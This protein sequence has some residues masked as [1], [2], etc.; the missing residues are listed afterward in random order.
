MPRL[1]VCLITK[2]ES[3]DLARCLASVRG[4]ADE[5][6]VVDTGSTDAT[7][8]IAQAHGARVLH[9]A[10]RHDFADAR[11]VSL[12]AATG[13]WVLVLDADDEVP[14]DTAAQI[15][16]LLAEAE[17]AR[18][19]IDGLTML[20]H[21]PMPAG[22]A[23]AF[24]EYP[25]LRLFRNRPEFRFR[26]AIHEQVLPAI[27]AAGGR[28]DGCALRLT[29]YGY[30]R[31]TVQGGQARSQRDREIIEGVLRREPENAYM[32]FQLGALA[33][34]EGHPGEAELYLERASRLADRLG[35]TERALTE[36][37]LS[38]LA[39]Q[40]GD[41]RAALSHAEASLAAE[42]GER[43][44]LGLLSWAQA[45]VA[46]GQRAADDAAA[47]ARPDL[48]PQAYSEALIRLDVS[49][50]HFAAARR[51]YAQLS[52]ATDLAT[53]ARDQMAHNRQLCEQ[54]LGPG[55]DAL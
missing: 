21:S 51:G 6:V 37:L 47:A 13:D 52:A 15:P 25:V 17:R 42:P 36:R 4:L 22:E 27:L 39:Y 28:V 9:H 7:V 26:Q 20:Y 40:A 46:L 18:P 55:H 19:P 38:G 44:T 33:L 12:D 16:G 49:R 50:K 29:H 1:S 45:H 11:N 32:W 5:I 10:W 24:T 43:N 54:L 48:P 2:N 3:R 53:A 34:R 31:P 35:P 23:V 8:A 14:S 30:L 41:A